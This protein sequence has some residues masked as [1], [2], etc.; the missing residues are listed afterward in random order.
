MAIKQLKEPW[1]EKISARIR[2][3]WRN[4]GYIIEK[5]QINLTFFIHNKRNPDLDNLIKPCID[6]IGSVVFE[7]RKGGR[8]SIWNTEDKWVYKIIAEKIH[9]EN[10]NQEGVKI[11]INSY[12]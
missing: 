4:N 9:V 7:K 2:E 6:G 12:P 8:S 3:E 11:L 10:N 5:I 1:K